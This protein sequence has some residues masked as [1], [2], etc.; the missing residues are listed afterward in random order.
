MSSQA[1]KAIFR[2]AD[3]FADAL[4]HQ[5]IDESNWDEMRESGGIYLL[6]ALLKLGFCRAATQA[7]AALTLLAHSTLN[8]DAIRNAG[9]IKELVGLL[10]APAT[11]ELL[12]ENTVAT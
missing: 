4:H 12:T 9:G 11:E 6:V 7:A 10:S 2:A 1:S 5:A 8:R 3:A